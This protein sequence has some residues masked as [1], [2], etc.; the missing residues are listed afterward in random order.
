[1]ER[2]CVPAGPEEEAESW[3][4]DAIDLLMQHTDNQGDRVATAIRDHLSEKDE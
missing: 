3:Y 1:M 4:L 2:C